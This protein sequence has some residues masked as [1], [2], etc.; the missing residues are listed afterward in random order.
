MRHSYSAFQL[1]VGRPFPHSRSAGAGDNMKRYTGDK[2]WGTRPAFN[3]LPPT[4]LPYPHSMWQEVGLFLSQHKKRVCHAMDVY[5]HLMILQLS[6]P[7][8]PQ[9]AQSGCEQNRTSTQNATHT[10]VSAA[11]GLCT[12]QASAPLSVQHGST[13]LTQAQ[14]EDQVQ[15]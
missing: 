7:T 1:T 14:P 2:C 8:Q 13:F 9:H 12:N 10:S 11:V 4:L 15:S 5:R 6:I 3:Q